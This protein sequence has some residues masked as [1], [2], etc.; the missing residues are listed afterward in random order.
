MVQLPTEA[1][2]SNPYIRDAGVGYSYGGDPSKLADW[3]RGLVKSPSQRH[4]MSQRAQHL[5]AKRFVAANVYGEMMDYLDLVA[6][7]G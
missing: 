5:Y 6:G 2:A 1:D 3:L 7:R 4:A